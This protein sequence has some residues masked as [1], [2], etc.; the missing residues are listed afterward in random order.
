MGDQ[1]HQTST[2]GECVIR[3]PTPA[4]YERMAELATQL[5][6]ASS[7]QEI[8]ARLSELQDASRYVVYVAA[9]ADG[10]IAG[11]IGAYVFRSVELDKFAEISGLIVDED[12]RSCGIGKL[13]LDAAE[14][15]ARQIGCSAISV[16][17]NVIRE[18]AHAFYKRH[19]YVQGKTQACFMKRF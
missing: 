5:G 6:Y 7:G 2:S 19:G 15:W 11:W 1:T 16:R 3:P 10:R 12:A 17:T 8:R 14:H 4:D 9:L 13:L 18:R